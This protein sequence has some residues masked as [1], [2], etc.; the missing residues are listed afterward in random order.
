MFLDC[1]SGVVSSFYTQ[2]FEYILV[3]GSAFVPIWHTLRDNCIDC[4]QQTALQDFLTF[5]W[6]TTG[7]VSS[8]VVKLTLQAGIH[9]AKVVPGM[10]LTSGGNPP[11]NSSWR[12]EN[13]DSDKFTEDNE[14]ASSCITKFQ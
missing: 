3:H 9:L 2:V 8:I 11:G 12:L 14:Y 5:L 6:T 7:H 4:G 1:F 10:P 13:A